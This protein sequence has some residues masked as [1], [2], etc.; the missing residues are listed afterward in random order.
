MAQQVS[1][2]VARTTCEGLGA[3]LTSILTWTEQD[4]VHSMSVWVGA[5]Y[6]T[7]DVAY[8]KSIYIISIL[9]MQ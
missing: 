3:D 7:L 2:M 8:S 4:F 6:S 9:F 5:V 1:W